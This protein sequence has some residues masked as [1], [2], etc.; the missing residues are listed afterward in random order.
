MPGSFPFES[1]PQAVGVTTYVF[2]EISFAAMI[3][4]IANSGDGNESSN[5]FKFVEAGD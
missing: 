4:S 1:V 5:P 2:T 3:A